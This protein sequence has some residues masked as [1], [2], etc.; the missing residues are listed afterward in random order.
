MWLTFV[1]VQFLLTQSISY[2]SYR[3][4]LSAMHF[5]CVVVY[6]CCDVD[7]AISVS[8]SYS[9]R[10]WLQYNNFMYVDVNLE[11]SVV[12]CVVFFSSAIPFGCHCCYINLFLTIYSILFIFFS[13][14]ILLLIFF[15]PSS[16]TWKCLRLEKFVM[17]YICFNDLSIPD[18]IEAFTFDFVEFPQQIKINFFSLR[19]NNLNNRSFDF[20][21]FVIYI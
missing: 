2:L 6:L 21:S 1:L 16:F 9:V 4:A 20:V 19:L 8:L 10:C 13:S 3:L 5:E 14:L 7:V 11:S 18:C 17:Q 15:M 12:L